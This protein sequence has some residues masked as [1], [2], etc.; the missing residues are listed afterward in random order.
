MQS[1][2]FS[3]KIPYKIDTAKEVQTSFLKAWE[4]ECSYDYYLTCDF[5]YL[6]HLFTVKF[7]NFEFESRCNCKIAII[8]FAYL[9]LHYLFFGTLWMLLITARVFC[10]GF[11]QFV[12]SDSHEI[13]QW[14][15]P[16]SGLMGQFRWSVLIQAKWETRDRENIE[17][18]WAKIAF[19]G[20]VRYW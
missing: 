11:S 17:R 18:T 20:S 9:I 19:N 6:L 8:I 4:C 10:S 16:E 12:F 2:C 13:L 1:S 15:Q 7:E 5:I 14:Q 3:Y